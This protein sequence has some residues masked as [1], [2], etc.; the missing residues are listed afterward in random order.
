VAAP[1]FA[2]VCLVDQFLDR[3]ER[4]ESWIDGEALVTS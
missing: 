2:L 1:L 4:A 3:A